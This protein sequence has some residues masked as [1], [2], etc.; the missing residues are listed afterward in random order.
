MIGSARS[1]VT[2][3]L[4]PLCQGLDALRKEQ[5][6]KHGPWF[7]FRLPFALTP[8]A[9]TASRPPGSHRRRDPDQSGDRPFPALHDRL[10]DGDELRR[11]VN[12]YVNNEDI[13]YLDDLNT[14]VAD[15]DEV[16]IIPAVAGG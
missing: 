9:T 8:G 15:K 14:P 3:Y 1:C 16:S 12:V 2:R 5:F 7:E 4:L 11:F 10:F 13:R 6:I